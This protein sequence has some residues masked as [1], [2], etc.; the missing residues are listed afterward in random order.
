MKRQ[1]RNQ[2]MDPVTS[3]DYKITLDNFADTICSAEEFLTPEQ[4]VQ[5]FVQALLENKN[6]HQKKTDYYNTVLKCLN[7]SDLNVI[8]KENLC[9]W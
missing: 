8:E 9:D 7:H 2:P 5:A 3:K 4:L 6:H 1:Q